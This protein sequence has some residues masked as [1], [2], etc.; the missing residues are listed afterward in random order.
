MNRIRV[1]IVCFPAHG[2]SG[3]VAVELANRLDPEHHDVKLVCT[4]RPTGLAEPV[5]FVPV[6]VESYP[7]FEHAPYALAVGSELIRL[8]EG[9]GLDVIHVHY[10]LPHAASALLARDAVRARSGRKL[11]IVC[12][13]H[14]TDVTSVGPIA[15]YE[16]I[17]R[18]SVGSADAITVPSVFLEREVRRQLQLPEG[19]LVHRIPNF[20]DA[21]RFHPGPRFP[22]S[23]PLRL[24]H[25]SNL[26]PVK[27]V[28][29]VLRAMARARRAMTLT[30]VGEGPERSNLED[31]ARRLGL[32][33]TFTGRRDDIADRLREAEVFVFP[34]EIESFGLAA[35]EASSCGLAVVAS[36]A[37]GLPEVVEHGTSGLLFEVGDIDALAFH[38]DR[39]AEEDSLLLSL[40]EAGRQSARRF[41]PDVAV[42]A[43]SEIY[44]SLTLRDDS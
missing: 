8:A 24:I 18:Y 11:R 17:L 32:S 27:R 26:R 20:V 19:R 21:E 39:L 28:H 30:V 2:G 9:P 7:L 13:L 29:D 6:Q 23:G 16:P 44:R 4:K 35:L 3:K 33:V 12:T 10:A 38:L 40:G 37:G 22:R 1:A 36:R 41:R 34:S 31:H 43:Y 5:P 42:R 15:A 25:V 14:G